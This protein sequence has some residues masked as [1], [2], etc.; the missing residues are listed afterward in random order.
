MPSPLLVANQVDISSTS[1]TECWKLIQLYLKL[2]RFNQSSQAAYDLVQRDPGQLQAYNNHQLALLRLGAEFSEEVENFHQAAHFWEQIT[3]Q[4][5]QDV[6]AWYGLGLARANLGNAY[7]PGAEMALMQA[8]KL[9]PNNQRI[10]QNLI[11]IQSILR[12]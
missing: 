8:L 11:N 5:P 4:Q 9:N 6:D 2:G 3:K 1:S 12:Q 7:L 10:Q